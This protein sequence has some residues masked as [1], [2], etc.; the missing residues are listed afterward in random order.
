MIVLGENRGKWARRHGVGQ[1]H[2]AKDKRRESPLRSAGGTKVFSGVVPWG[3]RVRR[4]EL[5]SRRGGEHF[6]EAAYRQRRSKEY[7]L[8]LG[9]KP[10]CSENMPGKM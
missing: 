4:L 5:G 6:S 7:T 2:A 3:R 8:D 9:Q 10:N 1:Y